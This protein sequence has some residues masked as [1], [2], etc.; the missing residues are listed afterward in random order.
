[1]PR[2][3]SPALAAAAV[4]VGVG[5]AATGALA[6]VFRFTPSLLLEQIFTDNV[7]AEAADRDADAITI[8]G[9]RLDTRTRPRAS[10]FSPA[11]P[12]TTTNTGPPTNLTTS[13]AMARP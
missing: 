10:S 6:D 9:L 5:A 7:R 2:H 1:M 8:V 4:L 12:P 11:A 13:T 3:L